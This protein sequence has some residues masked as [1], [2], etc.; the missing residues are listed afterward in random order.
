MFIIM[1]MLQMFLAIVLDGYAK[2]KEEQIAEARS[3]TSDI[4]AGAKY[5]YLRMF[6]LATQQQMTLSLPAVKRTLETFS[7][8]DQDFVSYEDILDGLE[9]DEGS[10]KYKRLLDNFLDFV[11]PTSIDE[12]STLAEQMEGIGTQ[13]HH[14]ELKRELESLKELLQ[15][16][17]PA[18]MEI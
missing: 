5:A 11:M 18:T 4:A 1:I 7:E 9:L 15:S 13:Y 10:E 17:S 8:N 16:Q 6:S 12:H 2:A 3:F 14:A